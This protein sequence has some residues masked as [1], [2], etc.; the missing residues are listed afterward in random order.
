MKISLLVP[1]Y[2][3]E[4]FIDKCAISLFE[5]TYG[6]IEYVFVDDC[7]PDKSLDILTQV[8][9]RYPQRQQ[10]VRIISHETNQGL[11]AARKTALEAATGDFVLNVDSDDYLSRDAVEKLV[12][13]QAETDADIVSGCVR[14]YR[15]NEKSEMLPFPLEDKKTF[16]RLLLIQNTIPHNLWGRLIR[17]SL[18]FENDIFP[19]KGVNQAEDYAVTPRLFFC[20]KTTVSIL[21]PLYNYQIFSAGTFSDHISHRHVE[22]VLMANKLNVSF[23]RKHDITQ[24][25]RFAMEVGMLNTFYIAMRVGL[26]WHEISDKCDYVPTGIFRVIHCGLTHPHTLKLLRL[27]YLAIKWLYKR[28]LHVPY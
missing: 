4:K 12:M 22:S 17:K 18:F 11:G 23:F 14:I 10:Q 28:Q 25:Y 9:E 15:D 7:T 19:Q 26:T 1:I 5:Q 2:G 16:L 6:D 27:S 20:A 21:E 13:K 24:S 8:L 3:V